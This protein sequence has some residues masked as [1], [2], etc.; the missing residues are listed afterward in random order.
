MTQLLLRSIAVPT[1]DMNGTGTMETGTGACIKLQLRFAV[2]L[3]L[4]SLAHALV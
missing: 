3:Y 1:F 4:H 2:A